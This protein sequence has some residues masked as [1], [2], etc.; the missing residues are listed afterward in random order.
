MESS[1]PRS[2]GPRRRSFAPADKLAHL[3][4]YEQACQTNEGGAYLRREGLYS[5][6]ITEWRKQRDAGVLDGKPVGAKVGKL[7]AEQAEIARLKREL[8]RT[9]KRLA[10]TE[11]ALGI[12]GKGS[13]ALG[14]SL[15]ERGHRRAAQEALMAAHHDLTGAGVTTRAATTLTSVTRST[16]ARNKTRRS[17]P[18]PSP[19]AATERPVPA[20]KLTAAERH[21]VL[22]MLNC[23]R[24]VDQAP[25]EVYAQLLDEGTYLCSV[26]T[27]YRILRENTQVAERRRQARHPARV[28][29]E[30]VAAGPR[31]VYTWDITKLPGP[32]KGVYYD[33]YVMVDIYSRYIVGVHVQSRESGLLAVDFMTEIFAV[34]G[35]PNVVHADRG[36]SMTSKP[37]AAL[38]ADLEVT[39]SHSRPKVSNDNPYSES[40]FKTLKYGP[41]FPE[42]FGSIH[43]A[44][45]FMD[46]FVTWY[47]HEHRHSGIGLHTPADVHFGLAAQKADDRSA[48][49]ADARRTHPERFGTSDRGPKILDLP[50]EAWI[51]KPITIDDTEP[52]ADQTAA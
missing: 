10:T 43:H 36:T 26:S 32:V 38:L 30:L 49:L 17:D 24:F 52:A 16:A 19:V 48:V 51:N 15:R 2:D 6:L 11:A 35:I 25:L 39:R 45:Q 46:S 23:N 27:M 8:A 33:A 22:T 28:C 4:A 37:V 21:Q 34:H 12:M 41:A 44:R 20:N 31:Q 47:N 50:T 42:H 13:R 5:S 29:P 40:L 9:N 14:I 18:S 3:A 7:T 1:H